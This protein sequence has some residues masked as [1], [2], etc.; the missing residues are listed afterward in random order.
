MHASRV[1]GGPGSSSQSQPSHEQIAVLVSRTGLSPARSR[2][3][4]PRRV[5]RLAPPGRRAGRRVI[6]LRS[7]HPTAVAPRAPHR[8][9]GVRLASAQA[10]LRGS[11]RADHDRGP[12]WRGPG[13]AL[14]RQDRPGR[15]TTTFAISTRQC[16]SSSP[17]SVEPAEPV[18]VEHSVGHAALLEQICD[19]LHDGALAGAVHASHQD[20]P[21]VVNG[22]GHGP[23]LTA[24]DTL[25]AARQ[26]SPGERPLGHGHN[27]GTRD[28]C[29]TVGATAGPSST[30]VPLVSVG[31]PLSRTAGAAGPGRR[32]GRPPPGR[33]R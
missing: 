27:W 11:R 4:W 25:H 7:D 30:S 2:S 3:S 6:A 13:N 33:R 21:R 26:S 17:T 18:D 31:Q 15:R 12:T 8:P 29:D 5:L 10:P 28:W 22:R 9:Q 24:P 19:V 20:S 32:P 1:V 16:A 23:F 14:L